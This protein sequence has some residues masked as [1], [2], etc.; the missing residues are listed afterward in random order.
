VPAAALSRPF[1]RPSKFVAAAVVSLLV[2]HFALAVGSK[3]NE[4]TTSDELVHL[5]AGFSYWQNHDYRLH[6]ENGILPQRWA[7]LPTWLKGAKFPELTGNDYWRTSDAWVV[8]HQFF[9]ETG[10]DHFPRLMA[11]RAM[12][13]LFS[14]GT[15]I[16]VFFWSWKFFGNAGALISLCFFAFSPDF[17]AHGGLVTSDVCMAFFFLAATGAWWRHLHDGRLVSWWISA[18]AFSLALVAKY[19]AVLLLPVVGIMILV[20]AAASEPLSLG[21][22]TFL[23]WRGKLGAAVLS[24]FAHGLVG[25]AT[26]WTFYGFRFSAFNPALP[27]AS[28]FIRPWATMMG[29]IGLAGTVIDAVG[30]LHL[31]PEAFLY[32]LAYVIET[33]KSRSAFLNGD[34]SVTGWPSFFVW[35]FFLKTT[36]PVLLSCLM[37][38][39]GLARRWRIHGVKFLRACYDFAPL[40]A[41]LGVY[42]IFSITSH[43][44]IGHR[45]V[46]PIYP[47]LFIGLGFMGTLLKRPMFAVGV[48]AMLGW[49]VGEAV[50]VAPHYLAYFNEMAGGPAKGRY[51]LVDSSLDW[52]Q[53][54]PGL[55]SWL[56]ENSPPEV[57]VFLSYFGTGEPAYYALPAHRI[58]FINNFKFPSSYIPL[59]PGVYCISA[60]ALSQVYSPF[61]GPWNIGFEKRYQALRELESSLAGYNRDAATRARLERELPRDR[62]QEIIREH[63]L[64]R[65]ARL[66]HYLR[67]RV[68]DAQIGYSIC[69]FR[70]TADEVTRATAGSLR[71]WSGLIEQTATRNL[72][73]P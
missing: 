4:S 50:F 25:A 66:C 57:P 7:A 49:H 23:T 68:P 6:P 42:W 71:D 19:T 33:T 58:S 51:H 43:L 69:I 10:E 54:L 18:F 64:L 47:V 14:V 55:K 39:G 16:L 22:R 73:Q 59:E 72:S 41:L 62:W 56:V 40:V 37:V 28:H 8:G 44:N 35:T 17:L 45:H 38:A 27:V 63:D 52:G 26:I 60:T 70:L 5:T 9:Y 24:G 65:F 12:I 53:D 15:G 29:D 67:L 1:T 61:R 34:Y 31:L 46:L 13:A 21:G 30:H 20:R 11:G 32:G 3:R 36:L 48:I 2:L